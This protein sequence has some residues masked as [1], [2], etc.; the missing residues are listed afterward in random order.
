MARR[1]RR[2]ALHAA[3]VVFGAI[4]ALHLLRLVAGTEITVGDTEIPVIV[5]LPFGLALGALAAWM[6][7]AAR[8]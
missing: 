3:A 8:R 5:S 1:T 2:R 6:V 7:L 4:A